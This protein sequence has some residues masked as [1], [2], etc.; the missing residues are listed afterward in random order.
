MK[1]LLKYLSGTLPA[2]LLIWATGSQQALACTVCYGDAEGPMIKA[3]S[4]GVWL[5]IGL[6]AALQSS[7]AL[8]FI[9]LW[10]RARKVAGAASD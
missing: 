6:V 1:K 9:Y 10:R 4:M 7:F 8:F 5:M 2:L 3:A